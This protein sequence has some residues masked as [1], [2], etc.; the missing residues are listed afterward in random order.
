MSSTIYTLRPSLSRLSSPRAT[1]RYPYTTLFRSRAARPDQGA[2]TTGASVTLEEKLARLP[3]RSGRRAS[4]SSR[5]EE[6]TSELQS[7]HAFVCRLLLEKKKSYSSP[8]TP[9]RRQPPACASRRP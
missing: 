1:T 7:H 9:K 4:F 5:S 8:K 3:D 6:H 2:P